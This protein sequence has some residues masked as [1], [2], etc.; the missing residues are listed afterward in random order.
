[1]F[2]HDETK[3]SSDYSNVCL[4][5]CL[6]I[7]FSTLAVKLYSKGA[8]LIIPLPGGKDN[9]DRLGAPSLYNNFPS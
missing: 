6:S 2:P 1:M 3:N 7:G 5:V 8:S 9:A 4:F